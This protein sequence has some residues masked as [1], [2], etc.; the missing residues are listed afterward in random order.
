MAYRWYCRIACLVFVLFT[1]YPVVTKLAEHRLAHDW[2]HSALH[3]ISAVVAAYAATYAGSIALARLFTVGV[4]VVYG[5]LGVV[6]WFIDGLLLSTPFA[7]PLGPVDNV[8][9]LGLAVAAGL[10]IVLSGRSHVDAPPRA[11]R[12]DDVPTDAVPERPAV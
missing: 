9:H 7:I 1:A 3:L 4:A 10:V 12:S 11:A 2:A 8:F 5:V 6:G